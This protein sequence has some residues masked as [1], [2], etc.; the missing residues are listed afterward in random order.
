MKLVSDPEPARTAAGLSRAYSGLAGLI[1]EGMVKTDDDA[2]K[3]LLILESG[4][5]AA[6]S[7]LEAWSPFTEK[8]GEYLKTKTL[9]EIQKTLSVTAAV[10]KKMR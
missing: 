3:N 1:G 7:K 4:Y 8:L 10:L 2:R 6:V 5:L 9:P